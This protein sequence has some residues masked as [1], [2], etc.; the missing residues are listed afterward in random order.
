VFHGSENTK[1]F[2]EFDAWIWLADPLAMTK[3]NQMAYFQTSGLGAFFD[4][5]ALNAG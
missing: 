4:G 1:G 5:L 2:S 3:M